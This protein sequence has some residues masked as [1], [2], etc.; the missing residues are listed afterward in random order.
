MDRV[1]APARRQKGDQAFDLPPAAEVDDVAK[2][3][4]SVGARGRLACGKFAEAGHQL[5]GLDRRGAVG[6]MDVERQWNLGVSCLA[7]A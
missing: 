5:G 3:A 2:L 4:A 6:K 1:G 7:H